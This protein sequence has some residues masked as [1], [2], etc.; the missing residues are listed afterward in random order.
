MVYEWKPK[1]MIKASAQ[2]AGEMCDYLTKN[3]GLTPKRLVDANR[4]ENAPL[5][6]EFEWDDSIAAEAYREGQAS[7]IIRHLT[8]KIE[9]QANEEPVRAFVR[10]TE[11]QKEYTPMSVVIKTPSYMEILME[12]ANREMR[13]FIKKYDSI[14][15][16]S[17]VITAMNATLALEDQPRNSAHTRGIGSIPAVAV[18]NDNVLLANSSAV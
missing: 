5:H 4:D 1:S 11:N 8:V 13:A 2:V 10:V 15:E 16:L 3:G 9:E 6:D 12:Q 17:A 14:S 7:H 18:H